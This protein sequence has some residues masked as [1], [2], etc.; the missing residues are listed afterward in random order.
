MGLPPHL[1]SAAL[2]KI[3][4]VF[5]RAAGAREV[6]RRKQQPADD[7]LGVPVQVRVGTGEN[8]VC[9]SLH[10]DVAAST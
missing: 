6:E 1:S 3:N 5:S 10:V 7:D 4:L 9:L 2:R 8:Q